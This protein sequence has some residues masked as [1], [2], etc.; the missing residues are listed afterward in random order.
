LCSHETPV[1]LNGSEKD[2][3]KSDERSEEGLGESAE[4]AI[5][6]TEVI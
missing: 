3:P 4:R 6:H 1:L 5:F 2:Y